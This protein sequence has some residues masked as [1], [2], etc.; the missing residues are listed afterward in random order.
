MNDRNIQE[1]QNIGNSIVA[2]NEFEIYYL[3]I[4]SD[5]CKRILF[6]FI[7]IAHIVAMN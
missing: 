6:D 2:K 5:I 1:Y 3:L 4:S 7:G